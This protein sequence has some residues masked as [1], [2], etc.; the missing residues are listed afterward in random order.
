M[1]YTFD[2]IKG[3]NKL[4][5]TTMKKVIFAIL[6]AVVSTVIFALMIAVVSLAAFA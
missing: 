4:I 3:N 6:I 5:N 1:N 2:S